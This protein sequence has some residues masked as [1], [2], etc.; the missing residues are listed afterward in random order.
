M[1]V[2]GSLQPWSPTFLWL[3]GGDGRP[4]GVLFHMGHL[5]YLTIRDLDADGVPEIIIE[6][7]HNASNGLSLI[8]LH[9]DQLE[10]FHEEGAPVSNSA[11]GESASSWNP[12]AQPC[13]FHMIIPMI[14]GLSEVEGRPNLGVKR[15]LSFLPAHD[16]WYNTEVDI[17]VL[18]GARNT[19]DYILTVNPRG[20][21]VGIYAN[22]PLAERARYWLSE[23]LTD[24]D[25]ASAEVME[26]WIRMARTTDTIRLDWKSDGETSR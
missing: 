9:A 26:K 23:G 18:I 25:F 5:E 3:F 20:E 17:N 1:L 11:A 19:S 6:G 16:G 14:P 7:I 4:R 13:D 8:S 24:I 22:A 2:I 21:A 10:P 12:E 15:E